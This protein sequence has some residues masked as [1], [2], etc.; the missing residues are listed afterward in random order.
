[1]CLYS[2]TLGT[3]AAAPRAVRSELLFSTRVEVEYDFKLVFDN[4][5]QPV[6]LPIIPITIALQ[7]Q[8]FSIAN[9]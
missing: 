4:I 1:M 6:L 2:F 9:L 5:V 8:I 7:L 3:M